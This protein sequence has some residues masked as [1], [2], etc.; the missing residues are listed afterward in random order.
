MLID[1][2]KLNAT[3]ALFTAFVALCLLL[4]SRRQWQQMGVRAWLL[5]SCLIALGHAL[6][7]AVPLPSWLRFDVAMHLILLGGLCHF[8]ACR[9]YLHSPM[10]ALHSVC[11][12]GLYI[13]SSVLS[14]SLFGHFG[15]VLL[16]WFAVACI[17]IAS[18]SLLFFYRSQLPLGA[19]W[20]LGLGFLMIAAVYVECVL[21][22][23]FFPIKVTTGAV[24]PLVYVVCAALLIAAQ[25]AKGMGFLMLINDRL[26]RTLR[27][28]A[29]QDALT[30]VLNRRGFFKHVQALSRPSVHGAPSQ[31]LMMLDIDHF[32]AIN[33]QYGHQVGD[34]VL[35]EIVQRMSLV[36]RDHDLIARYGGEEFVVLLPGADAVLLRSVAERIRAEVEAQPIVVDGQSIGLTIS[37]GA[38]CAS[39]ALDNIEASIAAADIALY[40]AKREGRNRVVMA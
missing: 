34:T 11:L 28:T 20:L 39:T 25:I 15:Y 2:A 5:A 14:S 29:E 35:R 36:L 13:F 18:F 3:I 21:E 10:P 7:S 12:L 32:K 6:N 23:L 16:I 9:Y 26:E 4:V 8:W 17:N 37:I 40:T 1:V 30:G 19:F 31:A 38:C 33:D 22:D 27:L 24:P